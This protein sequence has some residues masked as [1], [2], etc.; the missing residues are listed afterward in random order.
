M[1]NL[2]LIAA[3]TIAALMASSVAPALAQYNNPQN[4]QNQG[5]NNNNQR[6]DTYQNGYRAGYDDGRANR[7]YDDSMPNNRQGNG[8]GD[9]SQLW[10]Q[11]YS[12]V[13]TYNDDSYYQQCR[14]SADPAGVLAGAII[15]GL[16][17]N[18]V[19]RGNSRPAGTVAG[20]VIGGA[21]GASLTQNLDCNDRSYS[22]KAYSTAFNAGRP[23]AQ[24]DWNNPANAHRGSIHVGTYYNDPDG[25]RCTSFNQTIYINNR[26][27][28]A[29]GR[30][31]QQPDGT[32][33]IVGQ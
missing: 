11:R 29:T 7:R 2:K 12:R 24:Y 3:A 9:R 15:G 14:T 28:N 4:R 5:Q 33:A 19:T 32:W 17:G 26:P 13:Y 10:Q 22:Y 8:N 27:Q 1:K 25:F 6:A 16:L 31:C 20:I 30:A 23:N 21:L 18:A